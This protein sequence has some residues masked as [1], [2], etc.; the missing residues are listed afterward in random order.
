MI[1]KLGATLG[2]APGT[3]T[4]RTAWKAMAAA[5]SAYKG[6][7]YKTIGKQGQQAAVP[8]TENGPA[9]GDAAQQS[10]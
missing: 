3:D 8:P 9:A 5:V 7:T 2:K 1:Q 10:A 4:A 6:M